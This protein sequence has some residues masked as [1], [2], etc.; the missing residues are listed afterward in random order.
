MVENVT[1]AA[2]DVKTQADTPNVTKSDLKRK[3]EALQTKVAELKAAVEK[4]K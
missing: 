3:V 4:L 1:K 2:T